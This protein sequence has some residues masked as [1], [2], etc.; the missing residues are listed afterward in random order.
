M[1]DESKDTGVPVKKTASSE[2]AVWHPFE[3]LR[4]EVDR[5]FDDFNRGPW[6]LPF[7]RSVFDVEPVWRRVASWGLSPAVDIAEKDQAFEIT[8]ELPGMQEKDIEVSV[9]NGILRIKGEKKEEKEEKKKDYYLSERRYGAF[10]RAFQVPDG[11]DV[12]RITAA[13]RGGVLKL[14]LPK[15]AEAQKK[16]KKIEVKAG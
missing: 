10:E 14:T 16:E 4:R 7:Q 3:S 15:T 5:L 12:E 6:H 11:V 2:A 1:T 8:A 13:F 9:A